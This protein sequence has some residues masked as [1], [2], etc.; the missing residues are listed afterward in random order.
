MIF[1]RN[2]TGAAGVKCDLVHI[3][4]LTYLNAP[5]QVWFVSLV[6]CIYT[7]KC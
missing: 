4:N 2:L 7:V 5:D 3:P 1:L 6:N